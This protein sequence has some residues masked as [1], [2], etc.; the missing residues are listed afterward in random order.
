MTDNLPP[1]CS[2]PD[3]GIDHA[4][5]SAMERL[6]IAVNSADEL[7]HLSL[8]LIPMR[9]I[10]DEVFK[11]GFE[12]GE[13]SKLQE[14]ETAEQNITDD[15]LLAIAIANVILQVEQLQE[16]GF[17]SAGVFTPLRAAAK[18]MKDRAKSP[19]EFK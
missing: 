5:E 7:R 10:C 11:A 9:A 18:T 2:S 14:P 16:Q 12:E 3:G 19:G 8:L 17:L 4:F 13:L 6:S 15:E 1:G